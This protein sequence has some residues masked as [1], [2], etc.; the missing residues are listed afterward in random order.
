MAEP[1]IS[2][3]G[4][5]GIIG[6]SLTPEVAMRFAA[7][8]AAT[9][10]A[11]AIVL[12]R[13]GRASGTMIHAAVLAGLLGTG[14]TVLDANIAATP[15]VGVLVQ[16]YRAAGGIQI[17]ASH[18]PPEY[19]GLKL[20]SSEGRVIPSTLGQEVIKRYREGRLEWV[21]A[22][23][24]GTREI[25][26]DTVTPHLNAILKTVDVNRIRACHFRV[27]LDSNHG[28]GSVL[29][30]PLLEALGCE[31]VPRGEIPNGAFEHP[32]E[33]LAE[34]LLS[35]C[36]A[37]RQCQADIGF[38]QDPD[39]DRLAIIDASGR[40]LGEEYTL[41]LCLDHR[42]K[43]RKGPVV[44]NCASSRMNQDI[45]QKYGVPFF[46]SAVG[47]AN[48]VDAMIAHDAV[49][50]GEGNG[51]PIDPRVV[52]VRDSFVGMACVLDAMASTGCTVA[53]LAANLPRYAIVKTKV[54]FPTEKLEA[55]YH[56]VMRQFRDARAD[57]LD[58]LRLDWPD[59]WV[60]L[61]PSN[62]E[63]I[64]RII[65][66][67]PLEEEAKQLCGTVANVLKGL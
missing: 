44:T 9:A 45:A 39:G 2:V 6:E 14:R 35:I 54:E 25:C 62:T 67:A 64:V 24:V 38:C 57:R 43:T 11:G 32:P 33:P 63:P 5:R 61:R 30:L 49:F 15:T 22:A 59:R 56:A 10:P 13:D 41:S 51:G 28:A 36:D 29:G 12:A 31:V 16:H 65:A 52:L 47:E 7:A 66:E 53:E 60:L 37:V 18:N 17:T 3:S 40:Y 1:I 55:A 46:R 8:W 34:N 19:N 26:P 27:L 20:F 50:G 42:L 21:R 58:G 4:L 23:R 48:V